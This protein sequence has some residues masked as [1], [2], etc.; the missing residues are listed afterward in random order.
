MKKA[1]ALVLLPIIFSCGESSDEKLE[2]FEVS[3]DTL[4]VDSGED[5]IFH[6]IGLSHSDLTKD[7]KLLFN[8]TPK[9]E[10][11]VIDLDSLKLVRRIIMEREGPLG[12]GQPYAIQ[13]DNTGGLVLYGFNEVRFFNPD[14]SAM[15]R[16][17]LNPESLSG[18]DP[19]LIAVFNPKATDREFL[20]AI[21]EN[22]EQVPQGLAA[23]S[24]KDMTVRK[25]PLDLANKIQPYT[26]SLNSGGRG[27]EPINLLLVGNQLII[28]TAYENEA[29]VLNLE[30]GE[31]T[32]KTFQAELT[33]DKKPIPLKTDAETINE[34]Q[35]LR[36]EAEK[37][38][39]F[40]AFYFDNAQERFFRF[41]RDLAKEIGDSLVFSNV[42]TVFDKDLNQLAETVVQVDPFSKKFFK[43]GKLWSYVNVGDELGF[44]VV[45]FKF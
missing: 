28:S 11:E 38:V 14:L 35:E 2:S 31:L 10:I 16:Y 42:L 5:F 15:N 3:I 25:I 34:M 17:L 29:I 36:R 32:V 33:Q 41:S 1:I 6:Q 19:E 21:Y 37:S 12:T 26:Y 9:N 18:L 24:L 8:F 27:F 23:I 40:G 7:Q 30:T 13:F 45:D 43:D 20:Y 22:Y 44:V 4:F 39:R